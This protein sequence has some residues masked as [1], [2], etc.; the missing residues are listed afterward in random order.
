MLL[1]YLLLLGFNPLSNL[2]LQNERAD[3]LPPFISIP[4]HIQ[5]PHK[6]MIINDL[7]KKNG[8]HS[9]VVA[10]NNVVAQFKSKK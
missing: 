3:A 5:L 10:R 1:T 8:L 6:L 7:I 9:A 4:L 2:H